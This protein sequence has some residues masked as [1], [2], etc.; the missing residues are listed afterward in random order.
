MGRAVFFYI[1]IPPK[2]RI[3]LLLVRWGARAGKEIA[4]DVGTKFRR[5]P[6]PGVTD[7]QQFEERRLFSKFGTW[8]IALSVSVTTSSKMRQLGR[9][10]R[11]YSLR[12]GL[13]N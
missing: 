4:G 7:Y 8:V 3:R 5:I 11:Y 12:F 9:E 1:L 13:L 2:C 6:G 10:R